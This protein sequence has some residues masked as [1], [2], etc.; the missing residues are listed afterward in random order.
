MKIS[1]GFSP[2]PNDCFIF[3]A[4]VN[5][6][7]KT[8]GLEF[9]V[10]MEDVQT[11]NE[12]AIDNKIDVTKISYATLPPILENYAALKAGGALGNGTG[13]LLISKFP[14]PEP[15]IKFTTVAIPGKNTTAH[16]LFALNFPEAGN[17]LFKL[18]N[19][20]EDFVLSSATDMENLQ[21]VKTGV[22]IHENRFTYEKKGLHKLAD[23]GK[24]W[25]ETTGFPIPLGGI[26]I[27]RSLGKELALKMN[28]LIK[29][30]VIYSMNKLPA[31]SQFVKNHAQEM[32]ETVM[33]SHID[34]YV[35]DFSVDIGISGENAIQKFLQVHSEIHKL[36]LPEK[37]IFAV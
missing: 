22:I 19:E 33:R 23:L 37:E 4:L 29:E 34:L 6:A 16:V 21:E 20:I 11:L 30:S 32:E 31:I 25:E 36:P 9:E 35:N 10:V 5:G 24:Y 28:E 17:K 1:L 14:L 15:A 18:Y 2:C 27:K 12:L 3:D 13:P 26:V 7:I 8:E